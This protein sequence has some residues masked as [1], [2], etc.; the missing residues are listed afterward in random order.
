MPRKENTSRIAVPDF[1]IFI[2][3]FAVMVIISWKER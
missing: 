2:L 1:D 3:L